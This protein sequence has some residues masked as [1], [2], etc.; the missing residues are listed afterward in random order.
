MKDIV[1]FGAGGLGREVA[2][3]IKRINAMQLEW[4]LVGFYDDGIEV[5]TKNEY[6]VV[7]G[8]VHDLASYDKEVS[9][10]IA[11]GAP[12]TVKKIVEI[13]SVNEK[14][15]FPNLISPDFSISDPGNYSLG[16]GN[17]IQRNCTISCNVHMGNFNILNTGIGLGHDARMGDY[18]SFMPAVKISGEVTIGDCNFFG[19]GSI[20]LQQLKV[21][22]GIKLGAGS[23]LMRRAKDDTLY[24]GNPAKKITIE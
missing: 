18:N 23:V 21:G 3:L 1:I 24:M 2:C 11:I 14:L 13:L 9:V 7:L 19:V 4:N 10:A 8:N 20:V 6:G 22:N 15:K 5:G 12:K 17:I 16:Y